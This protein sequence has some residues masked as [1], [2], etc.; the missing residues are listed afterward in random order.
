M[1]EVEI[2]TDGS[3]RHLDGPGGWG[4]VII[5]NGM[6]LGISGF[7]TSASNNLMELKAVIE[8]LKALESPSRVIVYTDSIFIS[9]CFK[10]RWYDYW[11]AHNWT[12]SRGQAVKHREYWEELLRLVQKHDVKF[13][14]VKSHHGV[15]FN[16]WAHRLAKSAMKIV[17]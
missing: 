4:S 5:I 6:H 12:N 1:Q 7:V 13:I 16:E 17:I 10:Y 8:S 3:C 11:I 15:R 14:K 2:Y 9:N